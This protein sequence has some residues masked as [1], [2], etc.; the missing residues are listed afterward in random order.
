MIAVLASL[1]VRGA[2]PSHAVK[3]VPEP[4]RSGLRGLETLL[5]L[6]PLLRAGDIKLRAEA[7]K[8][9]VPIIFEPC[10]RVGQNYESDQEHSD[11]SNSDVRSSCHDKFT[12]SSIARAAT[13]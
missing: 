2:T 12:R 1:T 9:G 7:N 10:D 3:D 11:P 6:N 8:V 13:R 5:A 4:M